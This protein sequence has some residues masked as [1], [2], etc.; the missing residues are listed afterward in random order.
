M[1]KIR[2]ELAAVEL[3][4]GHP[5]RAEA[6]ARLE[7][8]TLL[9]PDRKDRLAG[10]YQAFARRLLTPDDPL[11]KPDP[12]AGY[13]LLA[14][15]RDLAKGEAL[16]ASLLFAMA[17]AG[18]APRPA[19]APNAPPQGG[20]TAPSIDPIR[21]FQAYLKE[22]PRGADRP[23]A[24]FHLGEAQLAARQ[25]VAARMTWADLA[26]DLA[27]EK[28]KDLVDLRARSLDRIA[29]THGIPNPPDD[30]QLNLGVAALRRYL[31]A[32]PAD[33]RAVRASFE[34][35]ESYLAR[36]RAEE[37]VEAFRAFL[38]G[39]GYRAETD[40]ARR[41]LADLSMTATYLVARTLQ[42]QGKFDDAIAGYQGYLARFPNGPQSAEAQR[43]ILDAHLEAAAEALARE[44]FA[45][46]RD[47][48]R[49][50]VAR[51]PPRR[52]RP[53]VA[54]SGRQQL[55]ARAEDGRGPCRLG[56]P[57][58]PVPRLRAGLACPGR[59]GRDPRDLERAT[60]SPR[61]NA[62]ARSPPISGRPRPISGSP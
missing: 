35:G 58:R 55:P 45:R 52:P 43:A 14:K 38:K 41:D 39:D 61:S 46:A 1:A 50:F 44:Q 25:F 37:A 3:A 47:L 33:P 2:S 53:G 21:D 51:Q 27:A 24:R 4:G 6:L 49:G 12:V 15:A 57:D 29:R 10:V 7:A 5:D 17:R 20:G 42:G 18:Q 62:I 54:L 13:S 11:S 23:A 30:A 32:A 34:I 59:R 48:W 56:H 8:E 26:K 16:R 36:N 28:A 9:A 22:Y 60:R 31:A 19:A 40:E